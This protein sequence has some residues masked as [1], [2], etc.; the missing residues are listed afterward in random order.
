[1]LRRLPA[2]ARPTMP[3]MSSPAMDELWRMV[4]RQ[5]ADEKL[6]PKPQSVG[7]VPGG[8]TLPP[9]PSALQRRRL[10]EGLA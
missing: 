9:D 1:M 10:E 7:D 5:M 2:P 4:M 3:S 8:Q 6:H